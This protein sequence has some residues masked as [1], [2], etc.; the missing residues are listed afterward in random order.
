M[1]KLFVAL[2]SAIAFLMSG[3]ST[4]GKAVD[5]GDIRAELAVLYATEKVIDGKATRAKRVISLVNEAR[6]F[7]AQE[8]SVTIKL[9][10]TEIKSKINWDNLSPADR[11][12]V[13]AVL[14]RARERLETEIGE[15]VLAD[16]QKVRVTKV[17][18]WIERSAE[19]YL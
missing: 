15:G 12:L 3:C 2:L 10:D 1:K 8:D 11:V 16:N 17:L 4:I 18:E 6:D 14:I 19:S 7:V 9:L 13:N 5:S